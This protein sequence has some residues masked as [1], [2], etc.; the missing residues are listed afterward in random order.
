MSKGLSYLLAI[1]A[2]GIVIF[3]CSMLMAVAN[4]KGTFFYVI[5]FGI[6]VVVWKGITSLA[7]KERDE[8]EKEVRKI[9]E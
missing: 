5:M 6:C 1:L 9:D 4:V 3:A 2:C 8:D 7:K